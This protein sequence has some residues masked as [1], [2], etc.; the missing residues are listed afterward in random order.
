VKG[1]RWDEFNFS[2]WDVAGKSRGINIIAPFLPKA[3]LQPLLNR[4]CFEGI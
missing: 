2:M 4:H 3:Q 1:V